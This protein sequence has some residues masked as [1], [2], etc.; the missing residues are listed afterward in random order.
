MIILANVLLILLLPLT[1]LTALAMRDMQRAQGP[2]VM[3]PAFFL[4]VAG[5][6]RWIIAAVALGLLIASGRAEGLI[7]SVGLQILVLY[8]AFALTDAAAGMAIYSTAP[9]N[10]VAGDV[11]RMLGQVLGIGLPLLLIA[12]LL[13]RLNIPDPAPAATR[14]VLAALVV[15]GAI[16]LPVYSNIRA[17]TQAENQRR[18]AE[19]WA[20]QEAR[21][22][23]GKAELATL[24]ADAPLE[25]LI[26]YFIEDWPSEV[27]SDAFVKLEHRPPVYDELRPMLSGPNRDLALAYMAQVSD[28]P[29][30][31]LAAIVR[32]RLI[33]VA[34]EWRARAR[35]TVPLDDDQIG[36]LG[37]QCELASSLSFKF[38][39][40]GV[41]F[42]PV[43][44]AWKV[45]VDAAPQQ[46]P[47]V[48]GA[49]S[50][51][52]F[53]R[54]HQTEVGPPPATPTSPLQ[55]AG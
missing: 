5:G 39:D 18:N 41:D 54:G 13:A 21:I 14:I 55:P 6:A 31:D 34:H 36:K 50:T 51:L 2:D 8:G 25:K 12:L 40:A 3:G 44:D 4:V 47:V 28:P 24:P 22:K 17:K 20:N 15:I 16:A 49:Q 7:P 30:A 52:L 32:D 26:P 23:Q 10:V 33:D 42:R 43:A 1:L 46:S 45:A 37:R 38:R 27:R 19:W 48:Q 29:P 9:N 35:A 11:M 53:W